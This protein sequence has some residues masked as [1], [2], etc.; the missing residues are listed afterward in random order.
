[1]IFHDRAKQKRLWY[2]PYLANVQFVKEEID[3]IRDSLDRLEAD[4]ERRKAKLADQG[5]TFCLGYSI[6]AA[7]LGMLQFGYNTGVINAPES[8]KKIR[9]H[10]KNSPKYSPILGLFFSCFKAGI[11]SQA[12]YLK[13]FR[14]SRSSSG[15]PTV[16]ATTVR[17]WPTRVQL[18]S[19]P[20]QSPS[21]P[22]VECAEVL[23]GDGWQTNWEGNSQKKKKID[24][25]AKIN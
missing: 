9:I 23:L 11:C 14:K 16:S 4:G 19:T 20:S 3:D 5:L 22:S 8:V 6:F 2:W 17:T 15:S 7:V 18:S 24:I 21:L 1:M 10:F 12:T 13:F 25:G